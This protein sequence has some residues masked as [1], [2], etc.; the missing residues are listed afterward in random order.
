MR[1][2][3]VVD[4]GGTGV[5]AKVYTEDF[6]V[7][8]S[9]KVNLEFIVTREGFIEHNPMRLLDALRYAINWLKGY[10]VKVA[11]ISTY[12]ASIIAWDREGTPLTNI[13]TWLDPRGKDVVSKPLYRVLRLL[14]VLG[15]I[16]RPDSPA[17][18]IKW[19]LE[20]RPELKSRILRG[21]AYIGT[22]SSYISYVISK[23][24]VNDLSNE[25]LTGLIHPVTLKRLNVVY[26]LLKIP[27][28]INP[29]VIDNVGYIGSLNGV[30]IVA[31]IADQ[32][33]ALIGSSCLSQKCLKITSGTGIFVD[34]P[35][36][37][38]TI[39][40]GNLIPLVVYNIKGRRLY[41]IEGFT[42]IGGSVVDWLLRVGLI[43]DLEEL[44]V[45][46]LRSGNPVVFIPSLSR[47][48][49]PW[50][51]DHS[52]GLIYGLSLSHGR[53]DMVRGALE[54]MALTVYDLLSIVESSVG[55]RDVI[56]ADGGLSN[57]IVYLKLLA[58]LCGRSIERVKGVDAT[59]RGVA[60]LVALHEGMLELGDF[61]RIADVDFIAR[62]GEER[63]KV[64]VSMWRRALRWG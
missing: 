60:M 28:V 37:H 34:A 12:R 9:T 32:Q 61:E 63:V 55:R 64:D 42:S 45:I 49:M 35:V 29:E 31:L 19:L 51:R 7:I 8:A 43:R 24:Y 47:T 46:A 25:A 58:S 18:K 33:A 59:S 1:R 53:E 2:Y 10:N 13:I 52:S 16:L 39:P 36:E 62:P 56:R 20:S 27:E 15:K 21:E 26:S 40:K 6:N 22:L 23:R 14:P 50:F 4:I 3:G 54:G 17:V 5:K 41:A 48:L 30:D 38:F 44:D 57:S 11:G